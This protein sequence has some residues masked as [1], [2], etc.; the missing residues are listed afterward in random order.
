[1]NN[2]IKDNTSDALTEVS[3]FT[4]HNGNPDTMFAQQDEEGKVFYFKPGSKETPKYTRFAKSGDYEDLAILGDQ[5]VVMKSNGTL[6]IFPFNQVWSEEA[7]NVVEVKDL[8]PKG[9]YESMYGD[10]KTGQ[11]YILC[12]DCGGKRS[13]S[14]NGYIFKLGADADVTPA[15]EFNIDT[16]PIEAQVKKEI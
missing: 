2:P 10:E 8:L 16:Q 9:E 14:T 3:G 1:M 13:K 11:L 4:F 12:K 5:V 6:Y 15:G 7:A